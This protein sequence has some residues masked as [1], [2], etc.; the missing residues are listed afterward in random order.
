MEHPDIVVDRIVEDSVAAGKLDIVVV[1]V[2]IAVVDPAV[3]LHRKQ[4]LHKDSQ[5]VEQLHSHRSL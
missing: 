4:L 2:D 5:F 1:V 3:E